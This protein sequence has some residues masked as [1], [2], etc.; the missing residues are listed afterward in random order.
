MKKEE[1]PDFVHLSANEE[2]GSDYRI[3]V[4]PRDSEVLILAPHGGKI[5]FLTSQIA[6]EIAGEDHSLYI[7][8]GLTKK[9]G[10]TL[11]ITS[12]RF[13]EPRALEIVGRSEKIIAIHGRK[14]RGEAE[15]TWVGGLDAATGDAILRRLR[16]RGFRIRFE[17]ILLGGRHPR[18]ICNRGRNSAGVQLEIPRSLRD[19]FAKEP[20]TMQDFVQAVR[21]ALR[22]GD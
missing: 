8:E 2:E 17:T 16:E 7:F 15:T 10:S 13:D 19:R 18:N 4:A 3:E 20:E 22:T 11:H 1:Y 12:D 14:D 9:E 5:E 6:R 21:E